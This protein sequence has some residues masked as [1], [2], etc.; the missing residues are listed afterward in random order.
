PRVRAVYTRGRH[1]LSAAAGVYRQNIIGL[2]DRRDAANIFTVYAEAPT[3]EVPYAVHGLA[4]YRVQPFSWLELSVEGFYKHLENLFIEEWTAFPRF[5]T[6]LQPATG[7]VR[8]I[9]LRMEIRQSNFYSFINY[10]LSSTHYDAMQESLP[11]WFGTDR[12]SFRPPH[13]RR[14][15]LNVLVSTS[16]RGVDVSARWNFGSGLPYTRVRGFDG[17]ILMDGVVDV[18][19]TE[20][21][22]RVIYDEPYKGILPTYHRLDVTVAHTMTVGFAEISLQAG[23]VNTYNRT[24]LFALDVFTLDR[25]DQLPL[26]PTVG[27]EVEL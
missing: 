7:R 23:V 5:T 19:E 20:G 15:Q 21:F 6:S 14:H 3:G 9:D 1:E 22:P 26:V 4:G 16:V 27:I 24:N 10:G 8:G 11:V 13:D 12:L 18:E 25:T 17:F 2:S